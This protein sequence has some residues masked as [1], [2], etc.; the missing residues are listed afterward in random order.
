PNAVTVD[1]HRIPTEDPQRQGRQVEYAL[2]IVWR[3]TPPLARAVPPPQWRGHMGSTGPGRLRCHR[4]PVHTACVTVAKAELL[5][6]AGDRVTVWVDGGLG[7]ARGGEQCG[8][9][10]R[11][12]EPRLG[13]REHGMNHQEGY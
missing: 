13:V 3:P 5:L 7:P 10:Q 1:E 12:Y 2:G 9:V 6:P 4:A 8:S 11:S